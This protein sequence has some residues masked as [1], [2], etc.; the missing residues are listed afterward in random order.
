[1]KLLKKQIK[2]K[3]RIQILMKQATFY[4]GKLTLS[5]SQTWFKHVF[6]AFFHIITFIEKLNTQGCLLLLYGM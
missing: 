3:T 2:D 6:N 4:K 1:M 5:P